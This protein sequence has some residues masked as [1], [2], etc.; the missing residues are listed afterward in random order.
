MRRDPAEL[1]ALDS[2]D[3][4]GMLHHGQIERI[5]RVRCDG[6]C[7]R[8]GGCRPPDVAHELPPLVDRLPIGQVGEPDRQ[9]LL[10]QPPG[11]A[12]EANRVQ[13]QCDEIGVAGHLLDR[14]ASRAAHRVAQ[15]VQLQS[16]APLDVTHS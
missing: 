11:Q 6:R 15:V 2:A 8:V 3:P 12:H 14:Y 9:A 1:L 10:T 16:Y 4:E 5:A 13:S 7:V